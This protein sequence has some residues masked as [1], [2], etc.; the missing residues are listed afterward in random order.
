[1]TSP[2]TST[3]HQSGQFQNKYSNSALCGIHQKHLVKTIQNRIKMVGGASRSGSQPG[4]NPSNATVG[5]SASA[6][7]SSSS[8]SS[9][10]GRTR[11]EAIY[12]A[13]F[14]AV[15]M[16]MESESRLSLITETFPKSLLPIGNRPLILYQLELLRRAGF[17]SEKISLFSL[18][19]EVLILQR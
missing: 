19:S 8:A 4:G 12:P 5:A 13:E 18:F 3:F 2:T 1:L 6:P 7:A 16:A 15:I 14:Q 17:E 10:V 9:P 11:E